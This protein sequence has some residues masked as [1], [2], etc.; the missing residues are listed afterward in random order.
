[1]SEIKGKCCVFFGFFCVSLGG[2]HPFFTALFLF[3]SLFGIN[4][5]ERIFVFCGRWWVLCV[6]SGVLPR[7]SFY[8]VAPRSRN[9]SK[10]S[11][12]VRSAVLYHCFSVFIFFSSLLLLARPGSPFV[13]SVLSPGRH[14]PSPGR[15][16]AALH[17][18]P[19][20]FGLSLYQTPPPS[21]MW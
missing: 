1:M 16:D 10:N 9:C 7:F 2:L 19:L 17:A 8:G 15:S 3:G 5:R 21:A 12:H 13:F 20:P 6:F 14:S 4:F 18:L 11:L